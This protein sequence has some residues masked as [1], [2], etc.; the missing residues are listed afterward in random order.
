MLNKLRHTFPDEAGCR[1][2]LESIIVNERQAK[3]ADFIAKWSEV[4]TDKR[5]PFDKESFLLA[6]GSTSG[7]TNRLTGHG[8]T[9]TIEGQKMFYD[10]FDLN[11]RKNA[12]LDWQV[13]YNPLDTSE[14]IAVGANGQ[15]RFLLEP[16]YIQPMAL[17]EQSEGDGLQRQRIKEHNQQITTY[18]TSER[19]RNSEIL[20]PLLE[21]PLLN[22]TLAKHLLVNSNG[23]HKDQRNEERSLQ[24]HAE[25]VLLKQEK[26]I[27]N[28]VAKTWQD[29]QNEYIKSKIDLSKYANI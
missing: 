3:Q 4:S 26:E 7:S 15:Q 19:Q 20:Q 1:K 8:L 12:N 14:A 18:I 11:F 23:Q 29:E 28:K 17:A 21:N 2:Q 25:K 6:L 10:N 13:I 27:E 24:A 9:V 22:D 5:L 16:K